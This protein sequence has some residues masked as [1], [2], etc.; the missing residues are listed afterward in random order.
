MNVKDITEKLMSWD[1]V[2]RLTNQFRTTA[3]LL[4][5]WRKERSAIARVTATQYYGVL[6]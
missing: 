4:E 3:A 1:A 6:V 5:T 2:T